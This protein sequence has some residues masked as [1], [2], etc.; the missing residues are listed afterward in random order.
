MPKTFPE[1]KL[2]LSEQVT[3]DIFLEI[4]EDLK[5]DRL[6]ALWKT[7]KNHIVSGIAALLVIGLSV[8]GWISYRDSGRAEESTLYMKGLE[9]LD[10]G[11][12]AEAE[13]V[14][15]QVR[16]KGGAYKTLAAFMQAHTLSASKDAQKVAKGYEV[17]THL[18]KNADLRMRYLATVQTALAWS[19]TDSKETQ[20]AILK[21][22]RSSTIGANP[23][24]QLSSELVAYYTWKAGEKEQA[25]GLYQD[26]ID[27]KKVL[28]AI[29]LRSTIM[30]GHLG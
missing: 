2:E 17:Y 12:T 14:F 9:H 22:L 24:G 10:K 20:E 23:W 5:R 4:Q 29:Q 8:G 26:L 15:A 11:E 18:I 27:D 6:E 28:P 21:A 13:E 30:K 7:Y 1:A 16:K 3:D 25:Q 19:D